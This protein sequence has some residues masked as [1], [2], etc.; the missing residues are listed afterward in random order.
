[1]SFGRAE[2][3]TTS[4]YFTTSEIPQLVAR[5]MLNRAPAAEFSPS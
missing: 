1:M 3:C 5:L 4:A 2:P